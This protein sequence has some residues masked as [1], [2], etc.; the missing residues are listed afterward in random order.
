MKTSLRVTA[1]LELEHIPG[2]KFSKHRGA[3]VCLDISKNLEQYTY[4]EKGGEPT[5]EGIKAASTVLVQGLLANLH[6]AHDSGLRDSAEHLRWIIAELERGFI[7]VGQTYVGER[8]SH[9][10]V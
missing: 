9:C 2:D 5:A 10:D 3:S 1:I 6:Y 7:E 4:F 8:K